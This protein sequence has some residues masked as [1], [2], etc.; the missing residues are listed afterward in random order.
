MLKKKKTDCS[1]YLELCKPVAY[2]GRGVEV[3]KPPPPRNSEGPL[4]SCQTHPDCENC[5][6]IAEFRTPTPQDVRKKCSKFLKLPPVRSCFTLGMANK[7][8]VNINS[9]QVPKVNKILL[10]EMKFLVPN[11]SRLQKP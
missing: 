8:D 11:Y 9:L 1:V 4:K 10:Y 5:V 6:K 7:L 2:R 3:F